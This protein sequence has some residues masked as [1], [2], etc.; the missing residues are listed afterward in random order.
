MDLVQKL[1]LAG[2]QCDLTAASI[3]FAELCVSVRSDICKRE[4]EVRQVRRQLVRRIG[5][6]T[7]AELSGTLKQVA[8][9]DASPAQVTCIFGPAELVN[10]RREK[11]RW[12]SNPASQND[13]CA[14]SQSLHDGR[15]PD[16]GIGRDDVL[17]KR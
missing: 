15:S 17:A 12:I 6:V 11:E 3:E 16:V 7:T 5:K 10:E 8:N 9:D 4:A 2:G 1:L 14:I 13:I